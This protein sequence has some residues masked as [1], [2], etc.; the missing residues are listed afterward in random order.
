[1]IITPYPNSIQLRSC[2]ALY[3][4]MGRKSSA[5]PEAEQDKALAHPRSTP[6]F[7]RHLL[8]RTVRLCQEYAGWQTGPD[9]DTGGDIAAT[10]GSTL[11]TV[12]QT[13]NIPLDQATERSFKERIR[14][15]HE[16]DAVTKMLTE[17]RTEA[18]LASTIYAKKCKDLMSLHNE[19]NKL[20]V[21]H[22]LDLPRIV[23][24]GGTSAGKKLVGRSG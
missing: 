3:V 7:I 24:I 6:K 20:G 18:E 19:L 14:G 1:M 9:A 22:E 8:G 4:W 2:L 12:Y 15:S 11:T 21:S 5:P 23:V 10:E 13:Q 16:D 17:N